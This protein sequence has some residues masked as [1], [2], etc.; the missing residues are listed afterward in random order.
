MADKL[1]IRMFDVGLGDCIY[2]RIPK[3]HDSG[4]DFH[5]LID[6]GT[7]S[8]ADYLTEAVKNLNPLLPLIAGKRHV[9][10]LVVTHEHKDHMTG[11][12]MKL[13]DGLSFGAIWMSAAMDLA[14]PEAKRAQKLH[15][16]AAR[17]MA[18]A[19]RLKLA[20]GPQLTD[21]AAALALNTNA[22]TMLR[23]TLPK[24]NKIKATYVHSRSSK[25]DLDLPLTGHQL[26]APRQPGHEA[27]HRHQVR[28]RGERVD[29]VL[30]RAVAV[31]PG[32]V[33]MRGCFR[34]PS[35]LQLVFDP[36]NAYCAVP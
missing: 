4:R 29:E 26:E 35:G 6:C 20:L 14:H 27:H 24:A 33:G 1:L 11:F 5:I 16:F 13:W 31:D 30:G 18:R 2:C 22:M 34:S 12:G 32:P 19:V 8:S 23:D 10:L 21:L 36:P 7:L 9:D 28:R 25:K 15:S 17:A 3:A